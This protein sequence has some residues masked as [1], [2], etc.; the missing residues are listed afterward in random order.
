MKLQLL[1]LLITAVTL[2]PSCATGQT[3]SGNAAPPNIVLVMTDDQGLGDLSIMGNPVLRTPHIDKIASEGVRLNRFYV[4]PV[5]TPTRASLM[6][7][8]WNFRTRAIDTYIGRAMMEPAEVTLAETLRGAGYATGIFGK[9]HLGDSYPLRSMDQGFEESLVHK[10]GGLR[11]PANPPEGDT[12]FNPILEHNGQ[13][14]RREGY[15]TDIYFDAAMGFI[16][17]KHQA[18]QPFFA[19]IPT[20]APHDPYDEVPEAEYAYYKDKVADDRDARIFAMIANIDKNVGKLLERLEQTGAAANTIVIYMHDNGPAGNRF[21]AGLRG[22][23]GQV[24]EGGIRSPFFVRWPAQLR[25]GVRDGTIGAHVDVM[26][27]L[28]EACGVEA[29]ANVQF[30]GRSLLPALRGEASVGSDRALFLQWHRGDV[31]VMYHCFAAVTERWKLLAQGNAGQEQ[32]GG[33]PKFQLFDLQIDPGESRDVMAENPEVAAELKRQYE[34]WFL[35]VGSTRPDNYAPPRIVAGSKHENPVTLTFQDLRVGPR[36]AGVWWSNGVWKLRVV[37]N[38][39]YRVRLRLAKPLEADATVTLL[40]N[41]SSTQVPLSAGQETAVLE[42]IKL[43][44]GDVDL[45][46]QVTLSDGQDHTGHY[47]VDLIW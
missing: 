19:Y 9:W 18:G 28:L 34:E 5:C 38:R 36:R 25:P 1:C 21:N 46:V 12:Y 31:P 26:P 39:D 27:T 14:V 8:R 15:C 32:P 37:G 33:E 2:L 40:V 41:G 44:R 10:G 29:P 6:T 4:S 23:K 42:H 45:G 20:N 24:F 22:T 7:G 11:Q 43:P 16:E 3:R 30:D 17:S 35:D 47:Q 13:P